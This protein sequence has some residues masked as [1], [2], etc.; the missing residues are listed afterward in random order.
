MI[1]CADSK[2]TSREDV[3]RIVG[4]WQITLLWTSILEGELS[5]FACY[6]G[7]AK[8]LTFELLESPCT[9]VSCI[10]QDFG[11]FVL[12]KAAEA[13]S[14]LKAVTIYRTL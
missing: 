8:K 11:V 14:F 3:V 13:R 12:K 10:L 1:C 2:W 6:N 5:R 9:T 4:V 7:S